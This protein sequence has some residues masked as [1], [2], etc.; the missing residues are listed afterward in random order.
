[1]PGAW[2]RPFLLMPPLYSALQIPRSAAPA[3]SSRE[4]ITRQANI[5]HKPCDH[6][7]RPPW[8]SMRRKA[9]FER[10]QRLFAQSTL[11]ALMLLVIYNISNNSM[12]ER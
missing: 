5:S 6:G 9:A 1:M 3:G 10:K 8:F 7:K 12:T 11:L 2:P 4:K